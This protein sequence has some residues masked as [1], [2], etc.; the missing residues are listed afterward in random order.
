ME[1]AAALF[2]VLGV[3]GALISV[4]VYTRSELKKMGS[5]MTMRDFERHLSW[6]SIGRNNLV[7]TNLND[8]EKELILKIFRRFR[9]MISGVAF[10]FFLLFLFKVF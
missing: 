3:L 1:K 9:F 8:K 6:L 2:F 5:D 7:G 4:H 10:V